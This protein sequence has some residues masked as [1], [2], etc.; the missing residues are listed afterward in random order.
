MVQAEE[1]A[2]Q[3]TAAASTPSRPRPPTAVLGFAP[4]SQASPSPTPASGKHSWPAHFFIDSGKK[5]VCL[6]ADGEQESAVA[7]GRQDESVDTGAVSSGMGNGDTMA[8][9]GLDEDFG[10]AW[11]E[12][13]RSPLPSQSLAPAPETGASGC[14]R[15]PPILPSL[16]FLVVLLA[17]SQSAITGV[18]NCSSL[19]AGMYTSASAAPSNIPS[20]V[21][22]SSSPDR[23]YGQ[24][25]DSIQCQNSVLSVKFYCR[26][27]MK[28]FHLSCPAAVF[29]PHIDTCAAAAGPHA[30]IWH[31]L[32]LW[33]YICY[34]L[35][36]DYHNLSAHS[37]VAVL[38]DII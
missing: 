33:V 12:S 2:Q 34:V 15:P 27:S 38:S 23:Q 24:Q 36:Q 16:W 4:P 17:G 14:L 21:Y 10:A 8:A 20:K 9:N 3:E 6:A 19:H 30:Y 35:Q 1:A 13:A 28:T 7:S 31:V 29:V 25:H 32:Q 22:R 5:R 26:V 11:R 37:L 18:S